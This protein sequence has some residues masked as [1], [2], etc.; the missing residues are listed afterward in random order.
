MRENE[1]VRSKGVEG[2]CVET[3]MT[4]VLGVD[5]GGKRVVGI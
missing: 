4:R 5:G 1:G 2:G 3:Q